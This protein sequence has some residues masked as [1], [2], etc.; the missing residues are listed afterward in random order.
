MDLT[1]TVV[2]LTPCPEYHQ[3]LLGS[4][5]DSITSSLAL[6]S[7]LRSLEVLLKPNLISA[8]RGPLACTEGAFILAVAGWF[9][10]QG[11]R[12][13]VG[14]S[15]AFGNSHSVLGEL[16]LV[17]PLKKL[18][19]RICDFDKARPVVLPSGVNASLSAD[20]LECDLLVNLPRVK[21]HCQLLVTMAVKNCFGCLVGMRKP[22][23]HMLHGGSHGKFTA[24]L[25]ELLGV[26]PQTLTLVDGI[27]AM[28]RIG[29][30]NGEPFPLG[31]LA[32]SLNPVAVDRA[33]LEI[34]GIAPHDSPLMQACRDKNLAGVSLAELVFPLEQP[35]S[36]KVSGFEVPD[37]LAPIRFDF[38]HYARNSLRR[39]LLKFNRR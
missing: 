15:P 19:V 25:V 8:K 22:L 39:L 1:S 27:S 31:L 11:A 28:H 26:L 37:Q 10:D 9:L 17:A 38:F 6:P 34:L 24:L 32:G 14:D 21:A 4:S 36:L 5:L 3:D 30:I 18:G 16:S 33:I 29:P 23:W 7:Q 20:A 2:A 12:V 35:S 13:S